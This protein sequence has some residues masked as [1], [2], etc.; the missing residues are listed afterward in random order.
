MTLR[1]LIL[2]S[3]MAMPALALADNCEALRTQIEAKIGAAGV[4][5]FSVT[6]VDAAAAST[7]GQ[8]VGSCAQGAKKI[9]YTRAASP[10]QVSPAASAPTRKTKPRKVLTECKDGTVSA[11][12]SCR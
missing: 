4:S 7:G 1:S 9:V 6:V 12:G 10:P 11:D 8:V 5:Q 3:A 2:M